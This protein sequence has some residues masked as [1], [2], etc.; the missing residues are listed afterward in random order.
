MARLSADK[1]NALKRAFIEQAMSPSQAA[2]AV[3]VSAATA[4]RYYD[5]WDV[6][7][8][9]SLERRHSTDNQ[10]SLCSRTQLIL[11]L[12]LLD[13]MMAVCGR[14]R[15]IISVVS[16]KSPKLCRIDPQQRQSGE[17]RRFPE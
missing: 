8:K 14:Q 3:G 9:R 12:S 15:S 16:T 1:L 10:I 6:E 7:I 17:T 4:K 11:V 2:Q 13:S 5:L